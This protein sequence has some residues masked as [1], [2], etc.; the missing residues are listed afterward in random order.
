MITRLMMI[1]LAVGS[2]N[3]RLVFRKAVPTPVSPISTNNGVSS[4]KTEVTCSRWTSEKPGT[5]KRAITDA[6]KY[7]VPAMNE[8]NTADSRI[9]ALIA[10]LSSC[11][12][13]QA[14]NSGTKPATV[15][16]AHNIPYVL[17]IT[18]AA[19]KAS[20][21]APDPKR[22]AMAEFL[23]I[24]SPPPNAIRAL[25]E[26]EVLREKCLLM[27]RLSVIVQDGKN[28]SLEHRLSLAVQLWRRTFIR[29]GRASISLRPKSSIAIVRC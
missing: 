1:L 20:V 6:A 24:S 11:S 17:G 26:T 8:L 7:A 2:R 5:S 4:R 25:M 14:E 13:C 15:A 16:L 21:S 22:K 23:R 10:G 3:L 28:R 27:L 19:K 12:F 9:T 18:Y 29:L